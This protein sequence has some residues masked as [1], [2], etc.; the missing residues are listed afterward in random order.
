M[1]FVTVLS[2][3]VAAV[4]IPGMVALLESSGRRNVQPVVEKANE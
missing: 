3:D 2:A 4:A 1:P